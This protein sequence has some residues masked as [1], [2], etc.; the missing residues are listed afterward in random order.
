MKCTE[1][2]SLK[3]IR[4]V[5]ICRRFWGP[6]VGRASI[7]LEDLLWNNNGFCFFVMKNKLNKK[8]FNFV[9]MIICS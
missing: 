3:A 8:Y 5:V 2:I 7:V 6:A 1:A 9:K 4:A